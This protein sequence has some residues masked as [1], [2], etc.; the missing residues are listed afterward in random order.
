M[1]VDV[2]PRNAALQVNIRPELPKALV[3]MTDR[4]WEIALGIRVMKREG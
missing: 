3:G 4:D 2:L 1:V